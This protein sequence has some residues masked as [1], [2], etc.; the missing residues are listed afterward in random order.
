MSLSDEVKVG[1]LEGLYSL[2]DT[3]AA[4]IEDPGDA[5]VSPTPQLARQLRETLREIAE[6]EKAQPKGSVVDDL[7]RRRQTRR[8]GTAG[9]TE[10]AGGS[11][12]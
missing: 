8:A 10:A 4:E 7:A 11:Q 2:R 12:Q 1:R 3:L 6:L 9:A 5:K